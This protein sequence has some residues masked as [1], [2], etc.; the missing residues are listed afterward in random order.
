[1]VKGIH[2]VVDDIE[3]ARKQLL[4]KKVDVGDVLDMSG[5]IKYAYSDPAGNTWAL[6][7]LNR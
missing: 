3:G 7:E 5:G 4:S 1:M 2:L 6:Q